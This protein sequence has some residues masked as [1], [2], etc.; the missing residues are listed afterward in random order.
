MW[1]FWRVRPWPVLAALGIAVGACVRD[2]RPVTQPEL[3]PDPSPFQYPI[4]LWDLGVTGETVLLL[5]VT[6]NG[7]VDSVTVFHGS[8]HADFDSAAVAG[9]RKLRFV[10]GRRG[11]RPV[12]MWTK[13]PVR[14]SLDSTKVG[15]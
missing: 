8:G 4:R 6:T 3:M 11:Q 2:D 14:F 7:I 5:H 13:L 1:Q 10:P 15:G 9:A 12:N